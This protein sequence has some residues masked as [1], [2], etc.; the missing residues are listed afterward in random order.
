MFVFLRNEAVLLSW[1]KFGPVPTVDNKSFF[2]L[3]QGKKAHFETTLS[4]WEHKKR[5]LTECGEGGGGVYA[6]SS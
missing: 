2:C 3:Q 5:R 1:S 6:V 4:Y